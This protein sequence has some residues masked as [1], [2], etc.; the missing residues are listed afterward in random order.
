MSA[1]NFPDLHRLGICILGRIDVR[2]V[3]LR[4]RLRF[5]RRNFITSS[6]DN[7]MNRKILRTTR[8]CRTLIIRTIIG[9]SLYLLSG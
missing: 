1:N 8:T 3:R 4:L 9:V 6:E 5:E 2:L 7:R